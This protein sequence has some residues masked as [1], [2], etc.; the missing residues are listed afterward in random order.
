M[1]LHN[2]E[3]VP[4]KCTVDDQP[5]SLFERFSWIYAFCRE[6]LL[7]DHTKQ[8]ANALCSGALPAPGA[9]VL[10]VG[11]GPGFYVCRLAQQF[12]NLRLTGIDQSER[13]LDRARRRAAVRHLPNCRF[14]KD[15]VLSLGRPSC[16]ID[17]LIASRLLTI[18]AERERALGEMHRILRPG[19]RCFIAE[20]RSFLRATVPLGLMW[21]AA[22]WTSWWDG[23]SNNY[24]EPKKAA[25]LSEQDFHKLV[26]SQ[27]WLRV[28]RWKDAWYQYA[29]CEKG[30]PD[31]ATTNA[32]P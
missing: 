32:M 31:A 10:E 30:V 7:H 27:N 12:Q 9:H 26:A 5:E 20:P 21:V 28:H 4:E 16:S 22:H 3:T 8:I 2:S 13:Q 19:G 1:H 6:H 17:F 18:I 24:K 25:V 15:D 29:V 11:C 23:K 14:E